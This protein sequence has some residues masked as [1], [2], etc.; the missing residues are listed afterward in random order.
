MSDGDWTWELTSKARDDLDA[1]DPTEQQ[2]IIDK[3]DGI[4][5]S[6]WRDPPDYGEPDRHVERFA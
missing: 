3:L 1:L 5:V 2:R 6:P 4:V